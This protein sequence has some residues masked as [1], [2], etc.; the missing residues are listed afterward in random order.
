VLFLGSS[1]GEAQIEFGAQQCIIVREQKSKDQLPAELKDCLVCT[2][3]ES[4]GLEFEDVL[5]YN[6]FKDSPAK[7]AGLPSSAW[8]VLRTRCS[9][10]YYM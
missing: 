3:F 7:K 1:H 8:S 4:K 9:A 6:F 2:V 10:S 5:V